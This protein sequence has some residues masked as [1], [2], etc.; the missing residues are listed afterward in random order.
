M[1]KIVFFAPNLTGGGAERV[2]SILAAQF[3][4]AGYQVDLILAEATGPYLS[5]LPST[6]HVI[7][8]Q[9]KRVLFTLPKLIK[10][11]LAEKPAVLFSS[12]MH[13]STIA[14][15][16][17]K[18][19]GAKTPVYIRQPTM[20]KPFY[21]K[22]SLSS[23][24]RQKI[25]LLSAKSAENVI[26]TSK[27]M[28]DEFHALSNVAKDKI[29]VIYNPVPIDA[30]KEKSLEPIEHPWLKTAQ[31]PVILAVGRF[32]EVKDFKTLIKAFSIVQKQTSA[33]LLILGEGTLR[34]ELAEQI[35]LLGITEHVLMPGFVSNPYQYMKHAKVF[36]LSS[37]WEG[38][39]NGMLEAMVCGARIVATECEGGTAEILEDGKWGEL[40]PVGNE[41]AMAQAMLKALS[42]EIAANTSERVENF[43][44]DNIFRQYLKAFKIEKISVHEE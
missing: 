14:L 15:W 30:I 40:V 10:Y 38:F 19:S 6:V 43:S 28:A 31:P 37:L 39:P 36:V 42:S 34:N 17:A 23:K 8:L 1:K 29:Q 9:C 26:V 13:S 18:L 22:Q 32:V 3:A 44:I 7:D 11:L 41:H 25:F 33:R 4:E 2:V 21:G 16:A 12:Q 20:L 5:N 35:E 27:V 24:L